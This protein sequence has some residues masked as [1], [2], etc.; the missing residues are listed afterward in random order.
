MGRVITGGRN[1]LEVGAV[2]GVAAV[3]ALWRMAFEQGSMK[4]GMD[5]ILHELQMLR[6]ELT[7]DIHEL[8]QRI[9]DHEIR[10]RD[11]ERR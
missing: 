4:R 8:D 3:G 7:K 11:L 2:I 10:I 9:S 6:S 1:V 5:G